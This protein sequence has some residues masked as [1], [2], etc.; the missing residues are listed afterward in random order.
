LKNSPPATSAAA[1]NLATPTLR[2]GETMS[3]LNHDCGH[4]CPS[5]GRW[6]NHIMYGSGWS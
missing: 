5:V 6:F 4:S 2:H 1:M 3:M